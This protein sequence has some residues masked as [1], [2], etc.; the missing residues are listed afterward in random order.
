[1][2]SEYTV[3]AMTTR[4]NVLLLKVKT[5]EDEFPTHVHSHAS[6]NLATYVGFSVPNK[7]DEDD[8]NRHLLARYLKGF[9]SSQAN[10]R[11]SISTANKLV[12]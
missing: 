11:R 6:G 3:V 5:T 10:K 9:G 4:C 7:G 8:T 12:T 2:P 1:M